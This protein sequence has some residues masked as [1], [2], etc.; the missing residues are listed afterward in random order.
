MQLPQHV[1]EALLNAEAK[2]LAT[3][4]PNGLNVVPVSSVLFADGKIWLFNYFFKKTL[5]NILQEPEASLV[6]W[7]GL[8]G[9]QV[10]STA[11]H[12]TTGFLFEEATRWVAKNHPTRVLKGLLILEP[13][14]LHDISVG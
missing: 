2:A 14:E 13:R 8:K 7:S 1:V 6:F 4:G 12:Y 11:M 9:Y 3:H 10:K 5:S